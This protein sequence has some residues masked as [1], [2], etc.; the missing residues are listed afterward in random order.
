MSA[1]PLLLAS[2]GL[3]LGSLA[4]LGFQIYRQR[5]MRQR[6][7]R[8]VDELAHG[9]RDLNRL[10]YR[11][12]CNGMLTEVSNSFI[13][14]TW[15]TLDATLDASLDTIGQFFHVDRASVYLSSEDGGYERTHEWTHAGVT[16]IPTSLQR[17]D[18]GKHAWLTDR[19]LS[20]KLVHIPHVDD[21][22]S[23]GDNI[24]RLL[25]AQKTLSLV[26]V[27]MISRDQVLGFILMESVSHQKVW[28]EDALVVLRTVAEIFGSELSHRLSEDEVQRKNRQFETL[29][30]YAPV[31]MFVFDGSGKVEMAVGRALARAGV[32][33]NQLLGKSAFDLLSK[34]PQMMLDLERGLSGQD[35][36]S[37]VAF[38]RRVLETHYTPVFD[39][40]QKVDKLIVIATDVTDRSRFEQQLHKAKLYDRVTGLPNRTLFLDR[41]RLFLSKQYLHGGNKAAIVFFDL[42]RFID[43]N[44]ALG[45]EAAN[46][47][48]RQITGRLESFFSPST[49]IARVGADEFAVMIENVRT[50]EDVRRLAEE[51]QDSL[52]EGIVL[53]GRPVVLTASIGISLSSE[54]H[55]RAEDWMRE[56]HTGMVAAKRRGGALVEVFRPVMHTKILSSWKMEEE[57][58][59]AL[60]RDQIDA[61]LQPIVDLESRLPVGFEALARWHHPDGGLIPPGQFIPIAEENGMVVKIDWSMLERACRLLRQCHD[62]DPRWRDLYVSVNIS[63]QQLAEATTL[64]RTLE[65]LAA[66]G[67]EPRHLKLEITERDAVSPNDAILPRLE[68]ISQSGIS[69]SLDDFGTGYSS[70]SYLNRLPTTSIKIDRSFIVN[71]DRTHTGTKVIASIMLMAEGLHLD[72]VAEGIETEEQREI[73]LG[74]GCRIGQGFLF[75]KAMP[76]AEVLEY[77]NGPRQAAPTVSDPSH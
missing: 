24:R 35:F 71:M 63:A 11:A 45:M 33:T 2:Q 37:E 47:A 42:D 30:A 22:P 36:H 59:H 25:Q 15:D 76:A 46:Q 16:P 5:R 39:E 40:E 77:L 54:R 74:M 48:L 32:I 19:I 29:L 18:L 57:L 72:I 73:L 6:V 67:L 56:A 7:H 14:S 12:D 51:A 75:A 1:D 13:R 38:G 60:S 8:L 10:R 70:L 66:H 50:E 3:A 41:L 43:L 9:R 28:T 17:L 27:P 44:D 20:R 53:D 65:I 69:L 58:S 62:S 34:S 21:I 23:G 61:W 31:A 68:A 4:V 64:S 52:R 26:A 55:K 49:L